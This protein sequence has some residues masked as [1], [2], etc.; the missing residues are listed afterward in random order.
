MRSIASVIEPG[1]IKMSEKAALANLLSW[2]KSQLNTAPGVA[3]RRN[4]YEKWPYYSV[5][6]CCLS[7]I[8]HADRIAEDRC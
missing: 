6:Y 4:I 5:K 7:D 3:N 2:L 8:E 1:E